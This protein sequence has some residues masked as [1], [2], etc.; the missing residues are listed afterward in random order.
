M[1]GKEHMMN[2]L[3]ATSL[4]A[5]LI[6][7]GGAGA[8]LAAGGLSIA[9]AFLEH[10]A[11]AGPVGE[12]RVANG[13]AKPMAI[14][15]RVRPW[16]Q[17]R[18]GAVRPDGGRTLRQVRLS[19]TAFTLAPGEV[20]TV[21]ATLLSR[22]AAGSLY[23]A[24]DVLGTP[25]GPR[26]RNGVLARSRLLGGLR[27]NPPAAQRRLRVRVG[28]ARGGTRGAVLAVRSTGNTVEPLTGSAR[29]AGA[30]GTLRGSIAGQRVLPGAVVDLRL[31]GERLQPGRYTAAVTLRQGGRQVAQVTRRFRVAR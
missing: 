13:S 28:A 6:A 21:S 2:R 27:L 20:R 18:S 3:G 17:P 10:E 23:G 12:V 4:A 19:A 30:T 1:K 24:I 22:P 26:P 29:I 9:P 25:Q 7:A 5:V 14:T 16:I 8:T 11:Q 31:S 15:V